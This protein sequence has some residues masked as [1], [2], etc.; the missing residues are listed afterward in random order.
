MYRPNKSADGTI[1]IQPEDGW[2]VSNGLV[3]VNFNNV[4]RIQGVAP[5][6]VADSIGVT[7]PDVVRT[8]RYHHLTPFVI[9]LAA[10]NYVSFGC[11]MSL[12]DLDRF[13]NQHLSV[14]GSGWL[15][16]VGERCIVGFGIGYLSNVLVYPFSSNNIWS[17]VGNVIERVQFLPARQSSQTGNGVRFD[18]PA[19]SIVSF[20]SS[21]DNDN[22]ILFCYFRNV[23]GDE[24][25]SQLQAFDLSL[26]IYRYGR[27][28]E[29]LDPSR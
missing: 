13:S 20:S 29:T 23:S 12:P 10:K 5:I 17:S 11:H 6:C 18:L 15:E 27:D 3:G 22:I 1:F 9:S 8:R 16:A 2:N 24:N 14:S 25:A 7:E 26:A 4:D 21:I 19:T 28:I